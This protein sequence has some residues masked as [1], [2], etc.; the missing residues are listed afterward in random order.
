MSLSLII[1]NLIKQAF[2][3]RPNFAEG[4]GSFLVG[5][6]NVAGVRRLMCRGVRPLSYSPG[7]EAGLLAANQRPDWAASAN[8]RTRT[9]T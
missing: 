6:R 5:I 1:I 2:F 7:T 8:Q 9:E 3:Y 4:R